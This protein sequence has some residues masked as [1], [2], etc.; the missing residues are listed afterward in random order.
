MQRKDFI[1]QAM[2]GG[3]AALILPPFLTACRKSD[4]T[5]SMT[6]EPKIIIIG[7]GIAGLSAAKKFNDIGIQVTLLESQSKI[8]GRLRTNNSL[9]FAFD[10]GASWIHGPDGNPITSLASSAGANTFL[11]EDN[12]L[13]VFDS[14]G[15][16]YDNTILDIN[17]NAYK[18][19][20][21]TVRTNG[22][23]N[24]SFQTVFN[25]QF[26]NKI[27]DRLWKYMLSA[28]LEF[29]TG[30]D[31]SD[32]S[33]NQFDDDENFSGGDVII[34]NGY[35]KI[36][37]YLAQ[38]I[39]ILLNEKVSAIDYSGTKVTVTTSTTTYQTD[40]VLVTVP[41][42]V[43]KNN[44]INFTPALPNDKLQA[45]SKLK[46]GSVNKFLLTFPSIFWDNTLQYIGYTPETKGKFNYFMNMNKFVQQNALMT[47]AFGNYSA[48]TETLSDAQVITE[49]MLHLKSIYGNSI[50]NPTSFLRTKWGV[51]PHTF[52]SYSFA[53][54]GTTTTD[55]DTL[56][57]SVDDKLFFAGEHTN[58][59]YRGTVH[60]AYLS[61][62]R[63]AD[64][65]IS[66][67]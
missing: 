56:S 51:N 66:L 5:N 24:Q 21:N 2:L 64:K 20:L 47:F 44:I 34:T 30:A 16:L 59:Q 31:I 40:F 14:N 33:S 39:N 28:Y 50:P 35:D 63:E 22:D 36:A 41:L 49:I 61:G 55:F 25:N 15:T 42:G 17:Y 43:L 45:I 29:D 12:S 6:N 46:M 4:L 58:K 3:T 32:L 48:F 9:G 19:S 13:N 65:I 23:I 18:S 60:G 52:G 7:G 57:N 1:K 53:T 26:P 8:G 27:N 54:T 11:T 62:L 10:E 67:L 37:Q 38:G